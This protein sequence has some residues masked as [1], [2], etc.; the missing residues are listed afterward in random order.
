MVKKEMKNK[1]KKYD[2]FA[3]WSFVFSLISIV[4]ILATFL[5]NTRSIDS[6]PAAAIS[7]ITLYLVGFVLIILSPILGITGLVRINK[8]KMKGKGF[9]WTGIIISFLF[10]L[11]LFLLFIIALIALQEL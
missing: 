10:L 2:K 9:A 1:G 7:L 11:L 3:I 8:N 6:S 5:I 4:V